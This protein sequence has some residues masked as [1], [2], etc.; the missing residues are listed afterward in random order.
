MNRLKRIAEHL[1]IS[2]FPSHTN[3]FSKVSVFISKK[4][5]QN[6]FPHT[7]VLVC[8]ICFHLSTLVRFRFSST[9]KRLKCWWKGQSICFHPS[10]DQKRVIF[11]TMYFQNAPLLKSYSEFFVFISV[12]F[13]RYTKKHQ[14][15][16]VFKGKCISIV[17]SIVSISIVRASLEQCNKRWAKRLSFY[18]FYKSIK[19]SFF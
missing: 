19:W 3:A 14:Q 15:L 2:P 11:K 8:L 13:S 7:S 6:I 12:Y 18:Y 17:I 5:K 9:L 16:C 1:T 4:A 10:H